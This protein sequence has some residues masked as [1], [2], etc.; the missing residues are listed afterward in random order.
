MFIAETSRLRLAKVTLDDAPFFVELMNSPHWI[1][2]IGDR[3]IKSE[4][5]AKSH[6]KKTILKSYAENGYG[7]YKVLL[8][9]EQ[10]K[11]IGISGLVKRDE[12]EIPDIGFG[13]LPEYEG[14]GYGFESASVVMELAKNTYKIEDIGAICVEI[15]ENSI[16]LIEKLGLTFQKKVKPFDD[17]EELLLFVKKLN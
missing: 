2:Y 3:N 11:T 16:K 15:N 4:E 6:L 9:E 8:K 1:K 14:K 17:D 7:F 10:F 12:L 13:F 5:D